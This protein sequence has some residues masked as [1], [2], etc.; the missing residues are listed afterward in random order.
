MGESLLSGMSEANV[1]MDSAAKLMQKYQ[2]GADGRCVPQHGWRICLAHEF[3]EKRKPF[4]LGNVS[5]SLILSHLP[6]GIRYMFWWGRKT[7]VEKKA[8][9]IDM[10]KCVPLR[11]I[12][13]APLGG[14]GGG[15]I[16]R[17]WRGEFCRWQLNPGLYHYKTVMENQFTVCIRRRGQTVYQQVL[18][19]ERPHTLQGWN[20]GYCGT[21]AFYHALYPRAWTVYQLPGQKVTLTCRQVSPII[22]HDYK[23]SSLPLA[24]LVWEVQNWSDEET[25]VVIMFTLRNGSGVRSDRAGGHWNEPFHLHKDGESVTGIQLHHCTTTNPYTLGVAVREQPGVRVSHCT[26]FD[27]SGMGHEVWKDLMEDGCLDST[28]GPSS[29]TARGKKTAVA[30]AAGCTVSPGGH[31]RL[32]FCLTWDMPRIRFGSGEKEHCRRYTRFFGSQGD[33]TP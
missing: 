27:P 3:D 7:Y 18:S 20:W 4:Q 22:P 29:V 33:V 13:G 26:H 19:V 17:G 25:E 9:F 14:I 31:G 2:G 10:V 16:T 15:T 5:P 11:Q 21:Q 8:P 6:M 28:S 30:L 12:Y 32:E 24:A 23:D 1:R